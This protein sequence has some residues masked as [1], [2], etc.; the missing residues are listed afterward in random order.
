MHPKMPPW[1]KLVMATGKRSFA[2]VIAC[3]LGLAASALVGTASAALKPGSRAPDFT[4]D[5]VVGGTRFQFLLSEA[6]KKGP[7]VLYFFPKAFTTGCTAEAHEFAAAANQF[8]AA[9]ATLI[10]M[11]GDDIE[12]LQRFSVQEC[13]SSFP[14]AADPKLSIIRSYDAVML[15]I[16]GIVG[17]SDRVSYVIG[18]DGRI[19]YV[20]QSS[21]PEKHVQN[22]LAE[23][24]RLS[25]MRP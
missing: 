21:D 16:P 22:T 3:A 18:S 19:S 12:T 5:A 1:R 20:Y 8:S 13:S 4:A 25:A 10:G 2:A 7:V 17:L 9:G 24:R 11:S 14:V 23:V 6:L 15:R